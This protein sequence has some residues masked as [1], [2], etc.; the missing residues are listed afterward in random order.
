M[1]LKLRPHVALGSEMLQ[2]KTAM[3]NGV[4]IATNYKA[5]INTYKTEQLNFL[6]EGNI[7]SFLQGQ[8]RKNRS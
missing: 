1:A 2:I 3:A 8:T 7:F 6:T 5:L 4:K